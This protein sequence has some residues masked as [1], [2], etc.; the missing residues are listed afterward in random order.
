VTNVVRERGRAFG[1]LACAA[2]AVVLALGVLASRDDA[3]DQGPVVLAVLMTVFATLAVLMARR[4][5]AVGDDGVTLRYT[6]RTRF[7]L[8]ADIA[9][10][11]VEE[12]RRNGRGLRVPT[13]VARLTSGE[14][15]MVPG[16]DP[17]WFPHQ[18]RYRAIDTLQVTLQAKRRYR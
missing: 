13:P 16:A 17:T 12:V 1:Q 2:L 8:W 4:G 3:G 9:S 10:F 6:V 7:I 5:A 18:G 14:L 15:V 11:G